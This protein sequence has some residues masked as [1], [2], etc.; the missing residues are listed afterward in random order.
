MISCLGGGKS[1]ISILL[2]V[3]TISIFWFLICTPDA[4][5]G[6]HSK[7]KPW[8]RR[9]GISFNDE[10]LNSFVLIASSEEIAHHFIARSPVQPIN[11]TGAIK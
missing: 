7:N 9:R 3:S 10:L 2:H 4:A 5:V 8:F 6:V 1:S 11:A